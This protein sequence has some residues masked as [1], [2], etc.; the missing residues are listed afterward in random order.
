MSAR[1]ARK[2]VATFVL[3]HSYHRRPNPERRER[4]GHRKY[5]KGWELR[6]VATTEQEARKLRQALHVIGIEAGQPFPKA[7]QTIVPVYGRDQVVR[8]SKI[9]SRFKKPTPHLPE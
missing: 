7:R 1:T 6:L 5:K 4:D 2:Y 9:A 8:L 3:H